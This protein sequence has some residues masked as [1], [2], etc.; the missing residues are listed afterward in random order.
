MSVERTIAEHYTLASLEEK[1]L[2]AARRAGHDPD[3][4]TS[5][6]LARVDEFHIGG[7]VAT[8]DLAGQM[9]LRPGM[10]LLD[11]GSGI[12]GPARYF[13]R[14]HGCHVVGVD[15]TEQY[16]EIATSL[17]RRVGLADAVA[18]HHA[19][20]LALPFAPDSFDGA[21]MLHVGMN[22]ED[23]ATLFAQVRRV[24]R[25]GARFTIY[26]VMRTGPGELEFP[27]PWAATAQTSF[28]A[29]PATYRHLLGEASFHVE[30][31]RDRRSFA[32]DFFRELTAAVAGGESPPMGPHLVMSG[33]FAEKIRHVIGA[34][35]GAVIA[36]VELLAR[37]PATGA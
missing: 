30:A 29:E 25:P 14:Q 1:I 19:S 23:K 24:L 32:I 6:D 17:S 22:I 2:D 5:D 3:Q 35:E 26:D 11:V 16:V 33:D 15:L 27:V 8:E 21:Y 37:T 31:E 28:V 13:A 7:R 12:G 4:L 34:L 10:R 20:A 9:G 36:P 18:F